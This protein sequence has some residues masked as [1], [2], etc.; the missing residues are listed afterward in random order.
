MLVKKSS[1]VIASATLVLLVL[2]LSAI[3]S[4][5]FVATLVADF[6]R[7]IGG[8][9]YDGVIEVLGCAGGVRDVISKAD[10]IGGVLSI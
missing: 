7:D 4:S 3:T 2:A 10:G 5:L 9:G 1:E 8:G 6:G